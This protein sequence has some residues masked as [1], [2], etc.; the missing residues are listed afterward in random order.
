MHVDIGHYF[1]KVW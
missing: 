1:D